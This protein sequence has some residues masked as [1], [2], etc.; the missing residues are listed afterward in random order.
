MF[1]YNAADKLIRQTDPEGK[2]VQYEY[3]TQG[4]LIRTID[5]SGNETL[6]EYEG[7]SGSSGCSTCTGGSAEQVRRIVYPTFSREF[8]YDL[9]GRKTAEHDIV[10]DT[11]VLTT[12][13]SYDAAGNLVSRTDKEGRATTYEY[14][15]LNRLVAVIDPAQ[16]VTQYAYDGRDNLISLTDAQG[17]TTRFAYDRSNRLTTE[18]R[19]MGEETA[20]TYDASG[21]LVEK[22]D[23]LNQKTGYTYDD[24]GRLVETRYYEAGDHAAPVKTVSFTYDAAGNLAGYDDGWT[25]A[26]YAYDAGG[27]KLSETV[28]YGAFTMAYGY[29][30]YQNGLKKTFTDP[31]G[32]VYAYTYDASNRLSSVQIPGAGYITYTGYTWE[33]PS[34]VTLPGGGSR[35]LSY[36]PLMRL[37]GISVKDPAANPVMDY[38]YTY[39]KMDNITEKS[40]GHG[41]YAYGYDEL[42]RLSTVDNPSLSDEAYTYDGVGNRLTSAET[43]GAWDYTANNELTGYDEVGFEYDANGNMIRKT[44]GAV[45]RNYLYDI[46]NRLVRVEDGSG[47]V[48]AEYY[49]DPFGRRL[50]KEAAGVRTYFCYADEGLVAEFD[51]SGNQIKSYGYRPG[52]T[53]TTDPLFMEQGGRYYFYHNDH[54]GTPQQMTSVSGAVVWAAEYEAFGKAMVDASST[55]TNNLRF[56]GQYYDEETGLHYNFHRYYDSGIGRYTS[57]DPLHQIS[58]L[59]KPIPFLI[60]HMIRKPHTLNGFNYSNQNPLKL[61]DATGLACGSGITENIIPDDIQGLYGSYNFDPC[62]VYHDDCYSNQCDKSQGQCDLEFFGCMVGYCL[63]QKSYRIIECVNFAITYY[64]GVRTFGIYPYYESRKKPPCCQK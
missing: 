10:S 18:T 33:R 38:R 21:N 2:V 42:Y 39:D 28:E 20:Y 46:E 49:Y 14:D 12:S 41:D 55:V 40:T 35:E 29:T 22:I 57:V 4:R 7:S 53:W 61:Y 51:A 62:C 34:G 50:W 24:A 25:S 30:Y 1:E 23:A 19:P 36:D 44:M 54:L 32:R 60:P 63:T 11:E 58:S 52:S 13:M 17:N 3:D 9:R 26:V 6:M 15:E 37:G 5:S 43:A 45:V 27:R 56:P 64:L 48:V 16:G 31:A 47:S 59:P 8:G